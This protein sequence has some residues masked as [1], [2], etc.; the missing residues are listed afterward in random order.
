[1]KRLALIAASSVI[2]M[3]VA[4]VVEAS[5]IVTSAV[6]D[7]AVGAPGDEYHGS[8]SPSSAVTGAFS[9]GISNLFTDPAHPSG[10]T[11]AADQNSNIDAGTGLFTGIGDAGLGYSL[12]QAS[13]VYAESIFDIYFTLTI[14]YDYSLSGALTA[15]VDG[16]RA[17]SLFQIFDAG[18]N[19]F[20]SFDSISNAVDYITP[21][22]LT[23]SGTLA[24][25]SYHLLVESIFDNCSYSRILSDGSACVSEGTGASM[26]SPAFN[27]TFDFAL[28]LTEA[29]GGGSGGT[30][31]E[32]GTLALLG[33]GVA[34]LGFS[35][36][37]K[38]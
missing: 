25:G 30:I 1:M 27:N 5:I 18:L 7:V 29:P 11:A 22:D 16:G 3:G 23:S 26:G 15:A 17:E 9:D 14:A 33:L 35:R 38:A 28:Q 8:S 32:P 37:K 4:Q 6:R 34:G 24:A 12:T 10:R 2:F 21:V 13:G 31:P 19:P 20:I 36:R